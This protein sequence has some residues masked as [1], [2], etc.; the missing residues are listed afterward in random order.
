M[1]QSGGT[2]ALFGTA[3]MIFADKYFSL[4]YYY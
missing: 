1:K 2:R 3:A 4:I